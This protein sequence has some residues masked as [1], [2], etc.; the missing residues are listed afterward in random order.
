[1]T[2]EINQ[3]LTEAVEQVRD[4]YHDLI[5][6]QIAQTTMTYKEIAESAGCSESLVYTVARLRGLSR[7]A[8]EDANG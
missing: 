7:N 2:N 6:G 4:R 5:A 3:K 1:M 8:K